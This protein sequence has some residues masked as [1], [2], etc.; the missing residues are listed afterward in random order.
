MGPS[1]A[2]ICGSPTNAENGKRF[3]SPSS[4]GS[5][6]GRVDHTHT[7]SHET[8]G[9]TGGPVRGMESA[10]EAHMFPGITVRGLL[11]LHNGPQPPSHTEPPPAGAPLSLSL[12]THSHVEGL[13]SL[14][15]IQ[16]PQFPL[17]RTPYL[18]QVGPDVVCP[19]LRWGGNRA[20]GGTV[21]SRPCCPTWRCRGVGVE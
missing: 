6:S 1:G 18:L 17:V 19:C 8:K 13:V 21:G 20:E 3:A 7:H 2:P 12:A 9:S 4:S 15:P 10:W 11:Q 14:G 16:C 5:F